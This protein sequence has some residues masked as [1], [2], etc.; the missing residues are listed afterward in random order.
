MRGNNPGNLRK[1]GQYPVANGFA[2][3]PSLLTGLEAMRDQLRLYAGRGINTI[4]KIV[5]TWAPPT[6]NNPTV[7]YIQHVCKSSG[8]MEHQVLDMHDPEQSGR[9]IYGMVSQEQGGIP[10]SAVMINMC[11][12]APASMPMHGPFPVPAPVGAKK[13][14]QAPATQ[15]T[16]QTVAEATE[17]VEEAKPAPAP[18]TKATPKG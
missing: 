11:V 16:A 14:E 4:Q 6:D 13:L 15:E 2:V 12:G 10:F 9:L 3:F 17:D 5:Y 7:A 1:W 18:P 8:Y